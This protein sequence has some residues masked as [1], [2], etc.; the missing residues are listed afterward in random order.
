MTSRRPCLQRIAPVSSGKAERSRAK[1]T[2][3][4]WRKSR[5]AMRKAF[6]RIARPPAW[7]AAKDL[8]KAIGTTEAYARRAIADALNFKLMPEGLAASASAAVADDRIG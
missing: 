5:T 8:V 2:K 6:D 7:A 3:N 4:T 1:S